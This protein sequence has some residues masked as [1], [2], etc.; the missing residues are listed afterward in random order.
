[1][2]PHV[3]V[4]GTPDRPGASTILVTGGAGYIGSHTVKALRR[5]GHRVVI[6]DD[7]SAGHREAALGAPLIE[8]D[9][10]DV[11]AVRRALRESAASGVMHFAGWL[12][13]SESV[14]DPVGY[15]RNN[16]LGAL[17]TLQAMVEAGCRRFVFSSTCAVYGEP[18]ELPLRETHPTAPVNAYGQT[19]LAVEQALPHFERAYGIRAVSLRYFNAAGADP[20]GELGEDH[21]PE[22]HAIPR[23]IAAAS[24]GPVFEIFGEDYP[25]PDGTCLR[26]Y[27]HVADLAD[28]H[29]RA[30]HHLE[31]GGPSAAYNVGTEQPSSVKDVLAAVERA[32]G[33]PVPRHAVLR[34]PGDPS[35]LYA[36]AARIRE[37]LGWRPQRAALDTIVGDAWRWHSSRPAGFQTAT[38]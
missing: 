1:M 34:R 3:G 9:V 17:A 11:D 29:L 13:V 16:V 18:R 22:I 30:L 12:L 31:G 37:E 7:L 28:A 19:K 23:A 32:T 36:S 2:T 10:R 21:D 20:E 14:R 25:T 15:Y 5:A 6:F 27:V 26:D 35:V 4:S 24:G 38:R 8:G 33:R